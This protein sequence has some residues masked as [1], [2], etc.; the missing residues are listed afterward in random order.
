MKF[1]IDR[2]FTLRPL[3]KELATGLKRLTFVENFESF[4]TGTTT[5]A[6][7]TETA[8]RN[9]LDFIPTKMIIL[10]Q[11]G[12]ALITAGTTEWT[13]NFLYI[14]NHDASNDAEVNILF[15]K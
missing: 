2:I 10:K 6:A 13:S 9:E 7:N 11:T 15:L 12:N 4:E 3:L 5:L 14:Q 1:S 8:I